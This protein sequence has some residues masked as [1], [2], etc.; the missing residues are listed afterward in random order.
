MS[1]QG[2]ASRDTAAASPEWPRFL[3]ETLYLLTSSC[4][5]CPLSTEQWRSYSGAS[6]WTGPAEVLSPAMSRQQTL[7]VAARRAML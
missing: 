4:L 7:A 2:I 3:A 1:M 6:S 5:V